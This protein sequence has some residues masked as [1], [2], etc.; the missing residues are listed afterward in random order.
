MGGLGG[1]G[2]QEAMFATLD[3]APD[4]LP[5][6]KP[7]YLMGVGKPDD[8]VGAVERGSASSMVGS[9]DQYSLWY[10]VVLAMGGVV[11]KVTAGSNMSLFSGL[12]SGLY[13]INSSKKAH[14]KKRKALNLVVAAFLTVFMFARYRVTGKWMPAGLV[15]LLSGI[16]VY[17]IAAK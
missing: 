6:D 9:R 11:G 13:F 8:I 7:R 4:M 2:G 17:N 15:A 3:F 14:F 10:G 1:G 12:L 16:Q 5:V